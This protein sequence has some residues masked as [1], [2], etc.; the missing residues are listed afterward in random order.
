ME[1]QLELEPGQVAEAVSSVIGKIESPN[2]VVIG[3]TGVGKSSLINAVFGTKLAQTG[4]GLAVTKS[5]DLYSN[6][7]VN[8]YDSAG[9]EATREREFLI[10][11]IDFLRFKERTV[12]EEQIHLVWYIINASSARV[13]PFDI[14][15]IDELSQR[16]IPLIIVLSQCDRARIEEID[17]IRSVLANSEITKDY[18]IIDTSASPLLIKG[19]PICE[20][21]GLV[22]LVDKT[23]SI[24]PSVYANAVRIAQV[25]DVKSKKKLA[26]KLISAA[27]LATFSS[28]FIPIPGT[29]PTAILALQAPLALSIA[30][31]YGFGNPREFLPHIYK[32]L[33]TRS[34]LSLA[35]ISI[36][37]DVLK[38]F[39]PPVSI[40]AGGTAATF[41]V[42]T[43]LAY[44]SAFEATSKAHIDRNNSEE[45]TSFFISSLNQAFKYYADLVI[46]SPEDLDHVKDKFIA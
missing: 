24:L 8:I 23:I 2:I 11:V 6:D 37:F 38:A 41:I 26:W 42:S 39:V 25:V 15:I 20:P 43:G 12:I 1:T 28:S 19:T 45:V 44:I 36:G 27:A 40:L 34:I 46:R 18:Q 7:L 16:H 35:G 4:A 30:S 5:F 14:S 22:E 9:Y 13:E 3:R 21:F 29:T 32:G 10:S 33:G 17:A 31:I